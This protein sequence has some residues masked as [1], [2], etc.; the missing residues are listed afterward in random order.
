[1]FLLAVIANPVKN[2]VRWDVE[3]NETCAGSLDEIA[4]TL[5][6]EMKPGQK[7]KEAANCGGVTVS[8]EAADSRY[9][10]GR[11]DAKC[12]GGGRAFQ[13]TTRHDGKGCGDYR[14]TSHDSGNVGKGRGHLSYLSCLRLAGII[15]QNG[16]LPKSN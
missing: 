11:Q 13:Q 16:P 10:Q 5:G 6:Q 15:I 3:I 7:M 4:A 8:T 9:E 14:Q 2:T 1:L 12:D